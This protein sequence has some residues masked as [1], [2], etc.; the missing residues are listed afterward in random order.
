MGTRRGFVALIVVGLVFAAAIV[1]Q[2][3]GPRRLAEAARFELHLLLPM[4]ATTWPTKTP[5]DVGFDPAKLETFRNRI[6]HF[7]SGCIIKD[8]FLVYAWGEYDR[9]EGW[10]SATKPIFSTLMWFAL[11]EN[12]IGSVDDRI[13]D[14]SP[15]LRV[16]DRSMTFRHL[17][18]MT[19]GY[20]LPEAPGQSWSYNDF[21]MKLY[22][23][24]LLKYGF[25]IRPDDSAAAESLLTAPNRLGSLAFEDGRLFFTHNGVPRLGMSPRDYARVGQFWLQKGQWNGR[26]ILPRALFEQ[27]LHVGVAADLPR[28]KGGFPQDYLGIGT[29]GSADNDQLAIGPGSYGLT[30]WFNT[31]RRLWPDLPS[32]SFQANGHL[33]TK[34][35]TIIPSRG[36]VV[37]W[38]NGSGVAG[39]VGDFN[40]PMNAA[41]KVRLQALQPVAAGTR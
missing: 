9:P 25:G 27:H 5:A 12:R 26:Q 40:Q 1:V 38:V 3:Y 14:Y 30:W 32:D 37:S 10:G 4:P 20:T 36:L 34:A 2:Y 17:A 23:L 13:A 19:S 11:H 24:T 31:D 41:L 28:T 7:S 35:V 39:N 8:G 6:G 15:T 21:G 16:A 18:N 29:M 33:N 22:F